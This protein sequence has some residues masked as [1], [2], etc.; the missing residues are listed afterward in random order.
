MKFRLLTFAAICVAGFLTVVAD[1]TDW[2]PETVENKP[3]TR[4][5]WLGSAVDPEGLTYNLEE[6]AKKGMGGVEITPIYGV[7]GNEV[8]DIDYLSPK[9]MD[10]LAY[11]VKE[12][13]RLGLQID[14][15]NGTGWPFGGP[16]ITTAE[17]AQKQ[18]VETWNLPAGQ[19]LSDKIVVK[20]PKQKEVAS[21][22]AVI[23]ANGDK[24]IDVTKYV[25]KDGTLNWKAPKKPAGDWT[26]YALFAGRT[27]QMVKRAAPGGAGYVL[28]HYDSTAVKKYLAKFDKAFEGREEILPNTFFN[29][30]YE[31]YGS[32]WDEKLLD[33]FQKDHGYDLRMYMPEFASTEPSDIRSR[34]LRDY[35][36]TLA[37]M[38]Y[39]NFMK[40]W[41]DW[42]HAKGVK[43]RNQSHGSPA[44]ILDLYAAVDI[45]ECETF[46]QSDF[47]IPGYVANGPSRKNDGDPTVLKF[48]SSAAHLMGKPYTSA[49]TLT[50]LTQHFRTSL[51]RCKPELDQMLAS[52]VN[53]IYFH[54]SPYSP[55]GVAFP[56][57][58]FYASINMSP[59]NSIWKDA[60]EFFEYIARSQAFVA[61][62]EPDNDFLLYFP[63]EDI[64]YNKTERPYLM[65][66]I[67]D[68]PKTMPDFQQNILD[69][70]KE[71]YDLDY[72]SDKLLQDIHVNADGTVSGKGK[73][74]Y[75]AVIVPPVKLME[76]ATLRKF[77]DLADQ[78]ATLVFVGSQPEDV[79]GLGN[80]EER[81]AEFKQVAQGL[82]GTTATATVKKAGKG[83]F[84][85]TP[86]FA[87][88]LKLTGVK[89]EPLRT[90]NHAVVLRRLNEAGGHNY[91]IT[92]LK[93]YP[94]D[95]WVT[96]ATDAES[97]EIFDPLTKKSGMAQL[98]K[99]DDGNTQVRL[100]LLPG[101]ALMLKTFPRVESAPAW[102]YVEGKGTPI[103]IT[104]GW[105]ISFPE[106]EPEIKN[107]FYT[108]T[109]TAWTN[110]PDSIVKVNVGTGR[111]TVTVNVPDPASADEWALD[112][113]DVRESARVY[114]NGEYAGT[115][116]CVPFTLEVGKFLKAGDNKIEIDVTN[117]PANRIADYERR[118]VKWRIFKDANI[119]SVTNEKTFSFG[120]WE[121]VPSGLNSTVTLTP[122]TLTK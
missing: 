33:E 119:A 114:I 53:H 36:S 31:V 121:T 56:G 42:A 18:I 107:V 104:N 110:L 97:A 118:G 54:G 81:R 84:I 14:M 65:F 102:K 105:S 11:T 4:W 26:V 76:T 9:W 86:D 85:T 106:S 88:A 40:V 59:T 48:A 24:R 66:G 25:T 10:M 62:G 30:S 13:N 57:W 28:N 77:L 98:R 96:L 108:D 78:G 22:Q 58:L 15:N 90:E 43:I 39:D 92:M 34:V 75:N 64:W 80:L 95:G 100:Q 41:L 82:P 91:Y 47:D 20:D 73:A 79:P 21:L 67:H 38:L 111:Y 29:D 44:N 19:K 17:S 60:E 117:L 61:A 83:R 2:Y 87:S 89:P 116:W 122:I 51:A 70:Q 93:N 49:E 50:W 112:L 113:G 99:D 69:I 115:A 46:G 23:A 8:N 3:Y 72:I 32:D 74:K 6:F 37:R 27:F 71:G 5:W 1:V 35:R 52:G 7:Q 45:P 109:L 16:E 55:K 103:E 12:G 94:I 63:I 68:M 101:E 120:D